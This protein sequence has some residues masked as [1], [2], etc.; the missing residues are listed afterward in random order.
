MSVRPSVCLLDSPTL[1]VWDVRC[2]AGRGGP[3]AEEHAIV[4]QFILPLDGVFEV[5]R[6]SQIAVADVASTVIFEADRDHRI[7]H[8]ADLGDHSLV[9]VFPQEIVEDA[10]EPGG[11]FGGAVEP[12]TFLRARAL[13]AGLRRNVLNTIEAEDVALGLLG[14]ISADLGRTCGYRPQSRHQAVR[15]EQAR[16]LLAGEPARR[17]HLEELARAVHCS[18]FHL[19]RQF[20]TVTGTSVSGYLLRLRLA[21]AIERLADGAEDLAALASDLGFASHSHFSARFRSVFGVSP[22]AARHTLAVGDLIELRTFLTADGS[23][24]P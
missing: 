21:G 22:G 20:R 15:I 14:G 9:L 16:E 6:G 1:E 2:K 18:P 11:P 4:T 19:A 8:P 12:R 13:A 7:G 5:H 3:G 23:L 10:L 24:A 17:W